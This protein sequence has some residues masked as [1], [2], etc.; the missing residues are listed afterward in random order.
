MARWSVNGDAP[1]ADAAAAEV[2]RR[3]ADARDRAADQRELDLEV[4]A[5]VADAR[6]RRR[7]RKSSSLN[8]EVP[9]KPTGNAP[10]IGGLASGIG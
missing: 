5:G 2:Q 4:R 9:K 6:D 7:M 3:A 10:Q 8:G 1:A